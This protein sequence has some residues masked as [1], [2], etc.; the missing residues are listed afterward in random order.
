MYESR[1]VA[2][3][4][5]FSIPFL[6][7]QLRMGFAE[8]TRMTVGVLGLVARDLGLTDLAQECLARVDPVPWVPAIGEAQSELSVASTS[9]KVSVTELADFGMRAARQLLEVVNS[10][11]SQPDG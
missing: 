2:G 1:F 10:Q 6:E 8:G 11:G 3:L 7:N 4:I 5:G 9:P